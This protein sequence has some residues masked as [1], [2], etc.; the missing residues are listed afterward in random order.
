ML[1]VA[2]LGCGAITRTRH[3][4]EYSA[5]QDVVIAGYFDQMPERAEALSAAYG[6]KVYPTM[7]SVLA[8]P[9]ID[10]VSVCVANTFHRDATI[11]ALE[12]G[13]H[14]LCEKPMATT[15]ADCVAMA[16]TARRTGK[17]LM[18]G[19]NQ[20]LAPAHLKAREILDSGIMGRVLTFSTAFGH[21][22][23]EKWSIAGSNATWFFRR[24]AAAM[25]VIGDLGIHKMD[26]MCYLMGHKPDSVYC[27][28][29]TLHKTFPDGTPIDVDDNAV[30][31]FTFPGGTVGT[32][33]LSWT[34][35]G[36]ETNATIL[37]CEKG[38]LWLY[39]DPRYALVR[40]MEDGA[41]EQLALEPMQTNRD[42]KQAASRVIDCFV[43][44]ILT[45]RPTVLDVENVMP[46]METVFACLASAETGHQTML[47]R[48]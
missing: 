4:P 29:A 30:V 2:I 26:V 21:A 24:D 47:S 16:E 39:S 6:G 32:A 3:C 9:A 15:W 23:P 19:M 44:G 22:G 38:T 7:D 17:R 27:K 46:A 10:A 36:Q 20:R 45:G 1:Q 31:I 42:K 8:D 43:E 34:Y 5:R 35:Y 48:G 37:A 40:R 33:T 18:I 25:G 41:V 13:K 28:L 12:A 11:R 14:V